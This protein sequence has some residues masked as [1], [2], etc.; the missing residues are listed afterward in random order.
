MRGAVRATP[1]GGRAGAELE[2]VH[3]VSDP[4]SLYATG[5]AGLEWQGA[6]RDL[7]AEI[8]AGMRWVF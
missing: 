1:Q 7:T 6:R 3:R 2:Y 8:M 5:F 4:L